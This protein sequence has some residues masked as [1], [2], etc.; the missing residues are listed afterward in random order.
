MS[1]V[2]MSVAGVFYYV[3]DGK[4]QSTDIKRYRNRT[5]LINQTSTIPDITK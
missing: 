2:R 4:L 3:Y 5:V 1:E